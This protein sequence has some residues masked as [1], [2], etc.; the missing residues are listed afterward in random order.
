VRC[1]WLAAATPV[2]VET[3]GGELTIQWAGQAD[4]PVAMSGP[5]ETVFVGEIEVPEQGD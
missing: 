5:A 4:A 1:G 2:T 3:R